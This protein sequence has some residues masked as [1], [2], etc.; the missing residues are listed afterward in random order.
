M[1]KVDPDPERFRAPAC[2]FERL[3]VGFTH[4]EVHPDTLPLVKVPTVTTPHI[5][6]RVPFAS[7][8]PDESSLRLVMGPADLLGRRHT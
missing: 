3:G 5:E 1:V 7:D 2:L 6:D 8:V 4:V